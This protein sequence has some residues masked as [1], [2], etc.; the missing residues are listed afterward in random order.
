MCSLDSDLE[1][2]YLVVPIKLRIDVDCKNLVL[3]G[4]A[5]ENGIDNLICNFDCRPILIDR[6]VSEKLFTRGTEPSRHTAPAA[7]ALVL[8]GFA[9]PQTENATIEPVCK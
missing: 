8:S 7:Q 9:A 4:E 1:D 3:C 5:V 6:T 2:L